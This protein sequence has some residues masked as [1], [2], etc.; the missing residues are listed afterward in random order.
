MTFNHVTTTNFPVYHVLDSES[1]ALLRNGR[2]RGHGFQDF[3]AK[4]LLFIHLFPPL[5]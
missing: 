3:Q 5:N 4:I 2:K 1:C